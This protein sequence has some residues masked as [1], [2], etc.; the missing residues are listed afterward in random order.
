MD[1]NMVMG[2]GGMG[3]YCMRG[4][5]YV[6]LDELCFRTLMVTQE[7]DGPYMSSQA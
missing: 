7:C 6:V 2:N 4:T 1:L 3:F 5:G